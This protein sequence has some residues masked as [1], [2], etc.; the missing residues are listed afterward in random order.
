MTASTDSTRVGGYGCSGCHFDS[1]GWAACVAGIAA[2][3]A[4]GG[5]LAGRL[6]AVNAP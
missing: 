3:L 6:G 1:F 4:V 5:A 2:A